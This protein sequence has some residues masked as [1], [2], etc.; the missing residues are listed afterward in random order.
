MRVAIVD[1]RRHFHALQQL[2][3][4]GPLFVWRADPMD[5]QR[6]ADQFAHGHP[7]IES[8]HR[9]LKDDLQIAADC[10]APGAAQIMQSLAVDLDAAGMRDKPHQCLGHGRLAAT[11]FS[12]Q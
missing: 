12:D 1:A 5:H 6:L 11:G 4:A 7:P 9:I 2:A 10:L 3:H 8:R